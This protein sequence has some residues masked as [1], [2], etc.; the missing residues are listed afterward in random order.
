MARFTFDHIHLRSPDPEATAAFYERVFGVTLNRS[1]QRI[2]F[3]LGGQAI[4]ISPINEDGTGDAPSAPYRGLEHIG[5]AVTG[6][7]A[8]VAEMKAQGVSFQMEPTT[9][10]PGVRIAFLRGPEN[11]AIE[12]LE[13]SAA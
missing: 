9:I 1:P 2:D 4:F 6:I 8:L 5:L 3:T 12:L 13:R 7:D 11:V 10:R